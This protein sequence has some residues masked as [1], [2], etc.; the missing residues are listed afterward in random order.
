MTELA[1]GT[2]DRKTAALAGWR[3]Q[4]PLVK[5]EK[6]DLHVHGFALA[7]AVMRGDVTQNGFGAE[8]VRMAGR[9]PHPAPGAVPGR[10]GTSGTA[11]RHCPLLRTTNR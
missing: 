9:S 11:P 2:D 4:P 1:E 6:G 5:D 7:R 8:V 3:Q 10:R